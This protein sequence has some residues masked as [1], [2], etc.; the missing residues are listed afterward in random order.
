M[1]ANKEFEG[2][3]EEPGSNGSSDDLLDLYCDAAE[4]NERATGSQFITSSEVS[5]DGSY[6]RL[7]GTNG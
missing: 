7:S 1:S 6:V 5:D 2:W 3:P 4:I